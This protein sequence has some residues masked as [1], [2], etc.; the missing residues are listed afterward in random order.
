M[1]ESWLQIG[2]VFSPPA[3]CCSAVSIVCRHCL[4]KVGCWWFVMRAWQ[5][6][7]DAESSASA[8]SLFR[9][10]R[11]GPSRLG[12]SRFIGLHE[13]YSKGTYSALRGRRYLAR[14]DCKVH[15]SSF[16]LSSDWQRIEL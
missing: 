4:P 16:G 1:A 5:P 10:L 13:Q 11:R 8:I 2:T 14:Q 9:V 3:M 12:L 15:N 7:H 6:S